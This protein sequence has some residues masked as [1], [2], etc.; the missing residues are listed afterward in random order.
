MTY[1]I[2]LIVESELDETVA[3]LE[4]NSIESLQEQLGKAEKAMAKYEGQREM[5]AELR[6]ELDQESLLEN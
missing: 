1:H 4:A 6:L 5:E 3:E 2:H